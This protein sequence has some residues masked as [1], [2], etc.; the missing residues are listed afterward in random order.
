MLLD[1]AASQEGAGMGR[2]S[3]RVGLGGEDTKGGGKESRP[4]TQTVCGHPSLSRGQS[5][6]FTFSPAILPL[7]TYHKESG[8]MTKE[9]SRATGYLSQHP[10]GQKTL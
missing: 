2:S 5:A 3:A 10:L 8:D 4:H 7:E 9:K 1:A 6:V